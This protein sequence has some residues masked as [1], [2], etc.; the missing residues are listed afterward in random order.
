M[1]RLSKRLERLEAAV[2]SL[3]PPGHADAGSRIRAALA[4]PEAP[5]WLEG[6]READIAADRAAWG[7][8]E[9]SYLDGMTRADIRRAGFVWTAGRP[10]PAT[11]AESSGGGRID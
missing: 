6:L 8:T 5:A 4:D 3:K 9:R 7:C 1:D 11:E 2:D 10:A